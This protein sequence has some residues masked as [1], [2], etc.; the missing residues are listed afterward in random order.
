[1]VS[2]FVS[3]TLQRNAD[4]E[5]Q[6]SMHLS[7]EN[8]EIRGT[9]STCYGIRSFSFRGFYL[10]TMLGTMWFQSVG[11]WTTLTIALSQECLSSHSQPA[12]C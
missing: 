2:M 3:P 4:V 6:T 8:K 5:S 1:M 11:C 12:A 10:I 9:D 7:S